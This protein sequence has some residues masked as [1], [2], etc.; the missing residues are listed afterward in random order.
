MR[1]ILLSA[2]V[3]LACPAFA[4][5]ADPA[6][7]EDEDGIVR[8]PGNGELKD[9]AR[10]RTADGR[11]LPPGLSRN[12]GP[13]MGK[14]R[15]VPGGGLLVSFDTNGDGVISEAEIEAGIVEQFAAADANGD[16]VLMPLEQ[17]DWAE[18]LPTRDDS[19][20]NPARFDPNL[21]RRATPE[22]FDSVIRQLAAA[23]RAEGATELR[24]ADLVEKVP[25]RPNR[26]FGQGG[27][28]RDG[29]PPERDGSTASLEVTRFSEADRYHRGYRGRTDPYLGM[30][31]N[32][33]PYLADNTP[34]MTG[35]L[36]AD[37]SIEYR[38]AG[39]DRRPERYPLDRLG[40]GCR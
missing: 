29:P 23:Y 30:N 26:G 40:T 15:L 37:G 35:R 31:F 6:P 16:G 22:E 32:I 8:L 21:D 27:P 20:A 9:E 34:Y 38:F 17:I 3:A 14:T 19:L 39:E 36:N 4:Q 10:A 18:A 13:R 33:C 25:E 11:S 2:L 12:Q 5:T 1:L 7:A 24:V 28:N